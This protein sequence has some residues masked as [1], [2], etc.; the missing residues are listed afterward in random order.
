MNF[1][2]LPRHY[3]GPIPCSRRAYPT[4]SGDPWTDSP[5]WL[6]SN[7]CGG[8]IFAG[9]REESSRRRQARGPWVLRGLLARIHGGQGDA[10]AE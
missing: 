7:P 6:E 8:I 4:N 2:I 1:T 9:D 3:G 10:M 5:S